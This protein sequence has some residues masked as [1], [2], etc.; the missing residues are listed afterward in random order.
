MTQGS[1][2]TW[3]NAGSEGAG[4]SLLVLDQGGEVSARRTG[5]GIHGLQ[6]WGPPSTSLT[7][8]CSVF[9]SFI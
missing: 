8:G 9:L 3:G 5:L 6:L 1:V 2:G 4:G 7:L